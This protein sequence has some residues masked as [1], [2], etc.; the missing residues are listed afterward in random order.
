MYCRLKESENVIEALK[1]E[2]RNLIEQNEEF[3]HALE[4]PDSSELTFDVSGIK[5]N[6]SSSEQKKN[7]DDLLEGHQWWCYI[8]HE[9]RKQF[10]L[11]ADSKKHVIA[12]NY[13]FE[14]EDQQELH[15]HLQKLK[16]N[17]RLQAIEISSLRQVS[18]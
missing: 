15:F 12:G 6:H 7:E 4:R 18:H 14:S 10:K 3:R 5:K 2:K 16:D 11:D 1:K 8:W 9:L 13:D 17:V